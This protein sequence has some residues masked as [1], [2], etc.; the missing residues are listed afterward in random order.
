VSGALKASAAFS[1]VLVLISD[2]VVSAVFSVGVQFGI[3][4]CT[5]IGIWFIISP[6]VHSNIYRNGSVIF[7]FITATV[8]QDQLDAVEVLMSVFIS[9]HKPCS[10]RYVEMLAPERKRKDGSLCQK[11]YE[12]LLY[13]IEL[14]NLITANFYCILYYNSEIWHLPKLNPILKN[15]LLVASATA[16]DL[17]IPGYNNSM[18][19][20]TTYSNKNRAT[21]S[22]MMLYKHSILLFKT[23]NA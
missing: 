7:D 13:L 2:S 16:L 18:S 1:S 17:C 11:T 5:S 14:K 23:L 21:P 12:R 3:S 15:H 9:G 4:G 22:Q 8:S 19:C 6:K 20:T 10:A